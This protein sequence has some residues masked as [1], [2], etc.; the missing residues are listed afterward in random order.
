[1]KRHQQSAAGLFIAV[2]GS[3]AIISGAPA[4]VHVVHALA[5]L[6]ALLIPAW[7]LEGWRGLRSRWYVPFLAGVIGG[8]V[9][10]VSAPLV[11]GKAER[12]NQPLIY[13]AHVAA[14]YAFVVAHVVLTRL[15]GACSGSQDSA[16]EQDGEEDASSSRR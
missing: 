8:L 5:F 3:L 16:V 1:M 12:F 14:S 2:L 11:I 4:R 15:L 6:V 7:A 9:W 13:P 10:D